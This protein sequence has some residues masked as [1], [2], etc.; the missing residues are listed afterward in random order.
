MENNEFNFE[1]RPAADSVPPVRIKKKSYSGVAMLAAAFF[2][3]SMGWFAYEERGNKKIEPEQV[4]V[5]KNDSEPY[6]VKPESPG[7]MEVPNADKTVYNAITSSHKADGDSIDKA[8][9]EITS[10]PEEPIKVA[11]PEKVQDADSETEADIE[12]VTPPAVEQKTEAAK[13]EENKEEKTEIK[14]VVKL[15]QIPKSEEKA[16]KSETKKARA[17]KVQLGSYRT[18][19]DVE[20]AW[21]TLK[22]KYPDLL[23]KLESSTESVKISGKGAF[24]RLQAGPIDI[25]PRAREICKKL[26]EKKQGC[27][28]VRP[29]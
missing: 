11:V 5:V 2:I 3:L 21:K 25:E 20:K 19:K 26:S 10:N 1:N 17:Y 13:I 24:W 29:Q 12:N 9:E 23:G 18:E 14:K 16:K 7:G 6:K 28:V 4:P 22:K 15:D 27:I 8:L